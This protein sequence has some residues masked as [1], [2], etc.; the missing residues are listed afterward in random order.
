MR[1]VRNSRASTLPSLLHPVVHPQPK[2][3]GVG[4]FRGAR[5]LGRQL[6]LFPWFPKFKLR[7][8]PTT[9]GAKCSRRSPQLPKQEVR[10]R[11]RPPRGR[12]V[13][14]ALTP[15]SCRFQDTSRTEVIQLKPSVAESG[16]V[17]RPHVRSRRR[18]TD[19]EVDR[20]SSHAL[21]QSLSEHGVV[22]WRMTVR[23]GTRAAATG[24]T[25][26]WVAMP[27]RPLRRSP[28]KVQFLTAVRIVPI[29]A[30][31]SNTSCSE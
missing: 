13:F 11:A 31:L 16:L 1:V 15:Q 30:L 29:H 28:L 4:P 24:G 18:A 22:E 6:R 23:L 21:E 20:C 12:E 10:S 2:R 5:H 26:H 14:A 27:A 19:G 25:L 9:R 7:A 3:V 8:P 17:K